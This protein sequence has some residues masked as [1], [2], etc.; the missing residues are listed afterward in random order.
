MA[1]F[2]RFFVASVSA[3]TYYHKN[4]RLTAV[5]FSIF[6]RT[7]RRL[8][9]CLGRRHVGEEGQ[10]DFS[11]ENPKSKTTGDPQCGQL[12]GVLHGIQNRSA[13]SKLEAG[14][15]RFFELVVRFSTWDDNAAS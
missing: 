12:T 9:W 11:W 6:H 13:C 3:S 4:S 15:A 8:I 14:S 5:N 1:R 7:H 10:S 2:A